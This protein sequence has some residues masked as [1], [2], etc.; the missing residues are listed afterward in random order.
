MWALSSQMSMRFYFKPVNTHTW[1]NLTSRQPA[2][3]SLSEDNQTVWTL[4]SELV[5]QLSSYWM[6]AVWSDWM[7]KWAN[8]PD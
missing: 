4:V 8:L 5:I 2:D 3:A 6:D 1:G 7:L